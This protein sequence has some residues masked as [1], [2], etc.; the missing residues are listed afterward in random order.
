MILEEH[1]DTGFSDLT[2]TM[3]YHNII[4]GKIVDNLIDNRSPVNSIYHRS[5]FFE[6]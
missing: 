5:L 6:Q 3:N 4:G 1:Q 2:G